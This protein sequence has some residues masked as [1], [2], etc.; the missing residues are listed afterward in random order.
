M[1]ICKNGLLTVRTASGIK[2]FQ[3][4]KQFGKWFDQLLQLMKSRA[5]CRP[6]EAI[7]PGSSHMHDVDDENRSSRKYFTRVAPFE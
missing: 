4:E 2:R 1:S 5:S 3:D 6:C 7:E